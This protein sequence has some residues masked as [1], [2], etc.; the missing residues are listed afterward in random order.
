MSDLQMPIGFIF[1]D[2]D[3]YVVTS[4]LGRPLPDDYID[5]IKKTGVTVEE[6]KQAEYD[7]YFKLNGDQ[8]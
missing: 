3:G 2:G 4:K 8:A 1:E 5:K 6:F 7:E